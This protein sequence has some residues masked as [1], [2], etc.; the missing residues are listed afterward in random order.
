ME[1]Y[2]RYEVAI[3][4]WPCQIRGSGTQMAVAVYLPAN[5]FQHQEPSPSWPVPLVEAEI[6]I[7]HEIPGAD[8]FTKDGRIWST[9]TKYLSNRQSSF[10]IPFHTHYF[11]RSLLPRTTIILLYCFRPLWQLLNETCMVASIIILHNSHDLNGSLGIPCWLGLLSCSEK[12]FS[13]L[14]ISSRYPEVQSSWCQRLP[15]TTS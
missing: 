14:I 12:H 13:K 4:H 6:A 9:E 11:C 3:L 8:W 15:H 7:H 1:S 10:S 5:P 2:P